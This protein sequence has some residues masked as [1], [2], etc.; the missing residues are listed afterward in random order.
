MGAS[1]GAV[2]GQGAPSS[3]FLLDLS[4]LPPS[5]PASLDAEQ[6]RVVAH[7]RGPLLVLA[8]PGTGKTTT[9][10]LGLTSP[11]STKA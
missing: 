4:P 11:E 7:A 2:S 9:I 5:T 10:A 3:R 6:A 1:K 8:G